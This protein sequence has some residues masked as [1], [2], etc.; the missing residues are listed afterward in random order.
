MGVSF[1][2]VKPRLT[3]EESRART[4][5]AVVDAAAAVFARRGFAAATMEEIA[6]EAGFTRGAV[7]S[8]FADKEDL[9]VAVLDERLEARVREI[10]AMLGADPDPAAFF[11][12]L[13]ESDANRPDDD[14]LTWE[15]LRLEFRLHGVRNPDVLPRVVEANR[16]IVGWVTDAV[17]Q[18]LETSGI[19]PP[20]PY[21]EV[22]AVVQALDEGLTLMRLV[23]P[24]TIRAGLF[25]DTLATLL[26]AAAALSEKRS[27]GSG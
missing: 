19:D 21:E 1:P 3:R 15:L 27:E 6:A 17:R 2:A 9:F 10:S 4:R 13:A 20:L 5:A 16:K 23:D 8:N 26:E 22:G 14:A 7:Y 12:A 18:V 11:A 24:E 25:G